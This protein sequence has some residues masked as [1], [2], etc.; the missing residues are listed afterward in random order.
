MLCKGRR[1]DHA[2][3]R[4]LALSLCL[5]RSPSLCIACLFAC[6]PPSSAVLCSSLLLFS[7]STSRSVWNEWSV[8]SL[9]CLVMI[10]CRGNG[11][12]L[13]TEIK[14]ALS[15]RVVDSASAAAAAAAAAWGSLARSLTR[16]GARRLLKIFWDR[17]VG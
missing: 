17:I 11:P 6:L 9:V 1:T 2:N 10:C 16:P 8:F 12:K 14:H 5:S 3:P 4:A 15:I 7:F 13:I